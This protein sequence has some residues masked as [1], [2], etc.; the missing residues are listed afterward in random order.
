LLGL[1]AATIWF[2][3]SIVLGSKQVLAFSI[4]TVSKTYSNKKERVKMKPEKNI[5]SG[6]LKNEVILE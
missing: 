2:P 3:I 1:L 5:N 4:H 6:F